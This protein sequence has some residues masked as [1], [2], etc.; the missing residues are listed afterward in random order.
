MSDRIMFCTIALAA[1]CLTLGAVRLT[2]HAI[3]WL[4]VVI[5]FAVAAASIAMVMFA[6]WRIP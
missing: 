3:G 5:A 4:H 6:T 2:G 1:V